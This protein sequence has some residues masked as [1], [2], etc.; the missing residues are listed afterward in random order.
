MKK[1][2]YFVDSSVGKKLIMALTGLFLSLFMIEHLAGNLLALKDPKAFN[3]FCEFMAGT[4]NLINILVRFVEVGLFLIVIYHI[5]NG[6]RLWF[7][8][9]AARSQGYAVNKPGDNSS[10]FSRFMIQSGSIV[11]IFL[12]IH[13]RTFFFPSRFAKESFINENGNMYQ[14]M[15]NAFTNPWYSG[16]Y[17]FALILLAFHL[18]HGVQSAFQTLG[19]RN[20]YT[21]FLK[22]F[23]IAF[24]IIICLGFAIIPIYFL[25]G[26]K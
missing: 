24:S 13:L 19:I 6:V 18:V 5:T 3:E 7:S 22:G 23:G 15:V 21:P 14:S 2:V 9:K 25:A 11:F 16:F 8:N 17:L 1:L 12:V 4:T 26:G 20:K 10:F